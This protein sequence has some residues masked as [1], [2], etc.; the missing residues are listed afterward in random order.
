ME[1]YLL[2]VL[3]DDSQPVEY[4]SDAGFRKDITEAKI[5]VDPSEAIS[6]FAGLQARY[7]T[8]EM[9]VYKCKSVV[10]IIPGNPFAKLKDKEATSQEV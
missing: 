3:D 1:G 4:W 7:T 10:E 6:T 9:K 8:V 2:S 5:Y